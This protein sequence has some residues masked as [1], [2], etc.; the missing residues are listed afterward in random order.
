MAGRK[1]RLAPNIIDINVPILKQ[2]LADPFALYALTVVG[3][4]IELSISADVVNMPASRIQ[5]ITMSR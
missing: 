2:R 4:K 3:R 5:V 1:L